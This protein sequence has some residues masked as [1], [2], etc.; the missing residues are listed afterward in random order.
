GLAAAARLT[1]AGC[2]VRLLEARDRIGGR[3]YTLRNPEVWPVP[4][5]LGAEFIQGR[6]GALL[7]IAREAG[8]PAIELNGTRW[9]FS[10]A[11]PT[12]AER[13]QRLL[14]ADVSG[15][16]A[17]VG[18]VDQSFEALTARLPPARRVLARAWIE[19]YDAAD[20]AQVSMQS[21]VRERRAESQIDG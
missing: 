9:Q 5:D 21:L 13:I 11:T 4:I 14:E 7:A 8:Q 1:R 17:D 2:D 18:A 16:A 20:P 3:V 6:V 19:G 10:G 15:L 12:R